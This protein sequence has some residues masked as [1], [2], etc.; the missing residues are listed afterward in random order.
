MLEDTKSLDRAHLILSNKCK[1]VDIYDLIKFP[2]Y[3]MQYCSYQITLFPQ[4]M[5]NFPFFLSFKND[6]TT[7][8]EQN[9]TCNVNTMNAPR[10]HAVTFLHLLYC[11]SLGPISVSLWFPF[12]G[13]T[14][15]K[16]TKNRVLL[17]YVSIVIFDKE[18]R[19]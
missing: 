5:I 11:R 6:L 15:N 17:T 7:T 3:Y 18:N 14:K 12:L 1:E 19:I 16:Q 10:N 13:K 9:L 4:I 8:A 2:W